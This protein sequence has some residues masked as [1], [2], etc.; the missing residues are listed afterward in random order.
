[1]KRFSKIVVFI[2]MVFLL[3]TFISFVFPKEIISEN[4]P[5]VAP[6]TAIPLQP[7]DDLV[8]QGEIEWSMDARLVTIKKNDM[9][10]SFRINSDDKIELVKN[11]I[12]Y[13]CFSDNEACLTK[14]YDNSGQ[15]SESIL[16]RPDI[17]N[18]YFSV[19]SEIK[20]MI[21]SEEIPKYISESEFEINR[22]LKISDQGLSSSA[23]KRIAFLEYAYGSLIN[24]YVPKAQAE[25]IRKLDNAV[26][27]HGIRVIPFHNKYDM[28]YTIDKIDSLY[29]V[30]CT[31]SKEL[32]MDKELISS[33]I[34]REMMCYSLEDDWIGVT[35]GIAQVSTKWARENELYLTGTD[36]FSNLDDEELLSKIKDDK[37][38]V[39]FAGMALKARAKKYGYPLEGDGEIVK[40]IFEAY[41]G[42]EGYGISLGK[43]KLKVTFGPI[44]HKSVYG[45]QTYQYYEAF[46]EYYDIADSY[47]LSN[48]RLK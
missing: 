29:P 12:I 31:T 47:S 25:L 14:Q 24:N 39:Y 36:K 43:L 10:Y 8:G 19:P 28:E 9:E 20:P 44:K 3:T 32:G 18:K 27:E 45:K 35:K 7:L 30:L 15:M 37:E 13:G 16:I 6:A 40:K 34:F 38:S 48:L 1:M 11:N 5:L 17:F 23:L 42:F 41:N 22:I 4:N 21:S 33:V 2:L 26:K 46:R